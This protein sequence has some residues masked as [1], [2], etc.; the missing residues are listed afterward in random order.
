[1]DKHTCPTCGKSYC[2]DKV[3]ILNHLDEESKIKI[4]GLITRKDLEKG[5]YLYQAGDKLNELYIINSGSVN[6]FKITRSG[7][8]QLLRVLGPGD[9]F[10]EWSIF[11]DDTSYDN[12]AQAVEDT[13]VCLL[14]QKDFKNLLVEYPEISIKILSEMSNRLETSEN[15][16]T[17]VSTS[18]VG[19]RL[20][21]YLLSH[22]D[23]NTNKVSLSLSRKDLSSFLGTTPETISRKFKELEDDGI[24]SQPATD[25]IIIEDFEK[26]SNFS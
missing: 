23:K 10:G 25:K 8:V 13:K 19:T 9:F 2:I 22:T 14:K 24:I 7:K 16:T 15:Q 18:Q 17:Q 5:E 3:S 1:M 6:V 11:T 4:S 20:A 12:Y 26:L 21:N